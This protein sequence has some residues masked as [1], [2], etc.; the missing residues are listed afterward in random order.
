MAD[1]LTRAQSAFR[2]RGPVST[3][4]LLYPS[5]TGAQVISDS[6]PWKTELLRIA[7]TLER[8]TTQRRWPDR[9]SF[10]VERDV[11]V[12]A[13]AIRRLNEARKISDELARVRVPV[14]RHPS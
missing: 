10:L 13:Y 7:G 12:A 8:R 9:S 4:T 3:R 14:L 5:R 11:M 6:I 2:A 1:F